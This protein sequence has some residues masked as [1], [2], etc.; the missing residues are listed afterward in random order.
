MTT[1][2]LLDDCNFWYH[3]SFRA[4]FYLSKDNAEIIESIPVRS[5]QEINEIHEVNVASWNLCEYTL[6]KHAQLVTWINQFN[7]DIIWLID[8][9]KRISPISGF[10]A[11]YT[12]DPL[13]N[14]LLIRNS[15][16]TNGEIEDIEF[17]I[18]FAGINFRYIRPNTKR[19]EIKWGKEIGDLNWLSNKWIKLDLITEE[20]NGKPGGMATNLNEVKILQT[21][22]ADHDCIIAKYDYIW[23]PKLTTSYYQLEEAMNKSSETG[24]WKPILGRNQIN[25]IPMKAEFKSKQSSKI[26]NLR[27]KNLSLKPWEKLYNHNE[28]KNVKWKPNINT[29]NKLE[30]LKTKALDINGIQAKNAFKIFNKLNPRQKEN[31]LIAWK[32][33]KRETRAVALRKKDKAIT[34]V[35]DTRLIQIYPVQLKIQEN[36]RVELKNWLEKQNTPLQYGFVKNRSTLSLLEDLFKNIN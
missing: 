20:R 36:A 35:L 17:G 2:E 14:V 4:R 1:L 23:K 32:D 15:L 33:L 22:K 8:C 10:R 16:Y 18:K 29:W 6:L 21:I 25:Y 19:T 30:D 28:N 24:I 34:S 11:I 12:D 26:V 31:L 5:L 3:R 13:I 9:R 27:D 7:L